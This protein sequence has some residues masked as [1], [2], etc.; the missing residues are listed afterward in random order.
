MANALRESFESRFQPLSEFFALILVHCEPS[1]PCDLWNDHKSLFV[2]YI[3]HRYRNDPAALRFLHAEQS[4]QKYVLLEI[5]ESLQHIGNIGLADFNL[6]ILGADL[7]LLPR[8]Q[9][10]MEF[11]LEQLQEE[12]DSSV[13]LFNNEQKL[14][15]HEVIGAILPGVSTANLNNPVAGP[16]NAFSKVSS[17]MLLLELEDFYE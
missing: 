14:A 1:D 16:P 5:E 8:A 2:S 3:R 6:P 9:E 10:F 7:P 11:S 17:S 15:F 4:A 12:A 13:S